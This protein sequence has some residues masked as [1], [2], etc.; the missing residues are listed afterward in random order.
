MQQQQEQYALLQEQQQAKLSAAEEQQRAALEQVRQFKEQVGAQLAQIDLNIAE[1]DF[2]RLFF[3]EMDRKALNLQSNV[4]DNIK[5][6]QEIVS[7]SRQRIEQM[8]QNLAHN[9]GAKVEEDEA[10]FREEMGFLQKQLQLKCDKQEA[11]SL[12]QSHFAQLKVDLE[13]ELAHFRQ[14]SSAEQA[15]LNEENRAQ[16]MALQ[17]RIDAVE[18]LVAQQLK[19]LEYKVE[20][21]VGQQQANED[22]KR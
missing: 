17:Q 22:E 16:L 8:C 7:G 6:I 18:R 4:N 15:Q 20:F 2:T 3:A 19:E 9:L 12:V 14:Q 10:H 21:A 5:C 1:N 13:A 11:K